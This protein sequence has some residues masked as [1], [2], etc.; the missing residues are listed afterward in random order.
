MAAEAPVGTD[1]FAGWQARRR[2]RAAD[3]SEE[4]QDVRESVA[5]ADEARQGP[6]ADERPVDRHATQVEPRRTLH[7]VR[8]KARRGRR[9]PDLRDSGRW[10]RSAARDRPADRRNRAEVVSGFTSHRLPEPH[11]AG[12]RD[13]GRHGRATRGAQGIQGQRK[14][15]GQGTVLVLGP[16]PRRSR[17]PCVR[18]QRGRRR[19][20]QDHGGTR[21]RARRGGPW[22]QLLRHLAG[23]DR[24]RF[25]RRRRRQR[26]RV[27]LRRVHDAD[28]R[29]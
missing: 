24:D 14:S 25:R 26:R 7:R 13:L 15:L 16:L 9:E 22:L 10:R 8:V 23:R 17:N 4:R 12:P 27:Q 3:R 5:G 20:G 29:R 11:L 21:P 6:P 28:R 2:R 19:A 1:D 18:D